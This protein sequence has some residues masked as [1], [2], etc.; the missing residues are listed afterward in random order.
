MSGFYVRGL[1]EERMKQLREQASL[2]VRDT[3]DEA[4]I[5]ICEALDARLR[6]AAADKRERVSLVAAAS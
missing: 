4:R 6:K 3:R 2:S 1:S 5:L